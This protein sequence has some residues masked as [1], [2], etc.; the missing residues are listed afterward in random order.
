[1]KRSPSPNVGQTV[2]Y[3]VDGEACNAVCVAEAFPHGRC[4][5]TAL[6][7][8]AVVFLRNVERDD[9]GYRDGTWHPCPTRGG[10]CRAANC[11][12][13]ATCAHACLRGSVA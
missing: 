9:V 6:V 10:T 12:C 1:M 4:T 11:A 3:V 5:V 7:A 13:R 8:G 2:H